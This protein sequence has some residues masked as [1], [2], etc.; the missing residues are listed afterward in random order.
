MSHNYRGHF[1]A[2]VVSLYKSLKAGC[3]F[4]GGDKVE[5]DAEVNLHN[6]GLEPCAT[7]SN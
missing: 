2:R 7:S 5:V 4:S 3:Y 6:V 1:G